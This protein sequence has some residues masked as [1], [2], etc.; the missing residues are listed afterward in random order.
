MIPSRPP[1][2]N[3]AIVQKSAMTREYRVPY[4]TRLKMSRPNWSVPKR[5]AGL[6]AFIIS[7]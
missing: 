7:A 4:T 2:K 6:G 1:L 5:C 3:A